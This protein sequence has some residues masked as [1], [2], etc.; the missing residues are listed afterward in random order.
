MNSTHSQGKS[1]LAKRFIKILENKINKFMTSVSK[2]MY[3]CKLDN[4]VNKH[5][6]GDD[7]TIKMKTVDVN[8]SWYIDFNIEKISKTLNLKLVIV[9]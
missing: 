2:S 4:I 6:K 7:R 5:N 1:F 8:S 9:L 3:T